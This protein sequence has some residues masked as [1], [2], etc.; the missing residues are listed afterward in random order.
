MRAFVG[1]YWLGTLLAFTFK[2]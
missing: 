1:A 2:Y